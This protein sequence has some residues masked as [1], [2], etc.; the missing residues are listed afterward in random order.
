MPNI[1]PGTFK[2]KERQLY[3]KYTFFTLTVFR[4]GTYSS[5]WWCKVV[6]SGF[7]RICIKRQDMNNV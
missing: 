2:A 6:K 4:I 7:K 3:E 5:P 1:Q